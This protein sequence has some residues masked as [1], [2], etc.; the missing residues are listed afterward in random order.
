MVC[1]NARFAV[2]D[3]Q[4]SLHKLQRSQDAKSKRRS[5]NQQQMARKDASKSQN[6][7]T[8]LRCHTMPYNP[9]WCQIL[10]HTGTLAVCATLKVNRKPHVSDTGWCM[11]QSVHMLPSVHWQCQG[12]KYHTAKGV[13][14][15]SCNP[16][17]IIHHSTSGQI[18]PGGNCKGRLQA[19]SAKRKYCAIDEKQ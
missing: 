9:S 16:F 3:T 10:P 6:S 5:A 2:T 19:G 13:R 12:P 11:Y 15:M 8:A 14:S 18:A 4:I 1:V 7:G 17:V